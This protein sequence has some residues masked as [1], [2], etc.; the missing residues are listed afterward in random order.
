MTQFIKQGDRPLSGAVG[1][2]NVEIHI[3]PEERTELGPAAA[4]LISVLKEI[5]VE[6]TDKGFNS[7]STNANA[8][9]IHIGDKR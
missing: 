5:G 4:A 2:T 7:H 3:R 1:A 6:A 8:I 9:H